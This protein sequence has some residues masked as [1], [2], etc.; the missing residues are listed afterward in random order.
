MLKAS[1]YLLFL[2]GKDKHDMLRSLFEGIAWLFEKILFIPFDALRS[3]ELNSWWLANMI[4][5]IFFIIAI[6]G[7][8][9]WLRQL[10]IF[11][12]RGEERH[13]VTSHSFLK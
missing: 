3:L 6:A 10:R 5:W 1:G 13:E 11:E 2:Q 4:S 8:I 7:F 12:K 9:Y